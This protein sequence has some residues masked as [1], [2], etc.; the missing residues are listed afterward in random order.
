MIAR[1]T[2]QMVEVSP[3]DRG[4]PGGEAIWMN[5]IVP[6]CDQ[7]TGL[8]TNTGKTRLAILSGGDRAK[9]RADSNVASWAV[10]RGPGALESTPLREQQSNDPGCPD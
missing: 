6:G 1:Q 5:R 8:G 9:L 2:I 4:R 10:D 7:G 3:L